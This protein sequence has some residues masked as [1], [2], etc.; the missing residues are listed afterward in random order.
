MIT[1]LPVATA[2]LAVALTLTPMLARAQTA[3]PLRP[4]TP[5]PTTPAAPA[6]A[7]KATPAPAATAAPAT[8]AA[9]ATADKP[10]AK[11]ERSEAQLKNDERMRECGRQWRANKDALT[12]QGKKWLTF[13]TECRA[14]LKAEGK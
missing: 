10:Q 2:L 1:R 13:S 12:K 8:N 7:P 14:K 6:T 11:R 4:A 5:A 9:P 3:N